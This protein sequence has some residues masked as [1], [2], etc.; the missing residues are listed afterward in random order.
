[1]RNLIS[2]DRLRRWWEMTLPIIERKPVQGV[3][4]EF[5]RSPSHRK[6]KSPL[7]LC[8]H[9]CYAGWEGLNIRAPICLIFPTW[10]YSLKT[11]DSPIGLFVS[12]WN[13]NT[14]RGLQSACTAFSSPISSLERIKSQPHNYVSCWFIRFLIFKRCSDAAKLRLFNVWDVAAYDIF[15]L[16]PHWRPPF[17]RQPYNSILHYFD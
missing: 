5:N 14:S 4:S 12:Y 16:L 8:W 6:S 2:G 7:Q 9:E 11:F 3:L 15:N 1:M 13:L 17:Y 10:R